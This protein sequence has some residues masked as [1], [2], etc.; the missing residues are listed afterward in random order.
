MKCG[1]SFSYVPSSLILET[2]IDAHLA[3]K[4][5]GAFYSARSFMT[6]STKARRWTLSL[7]DT[8]CTPITTS[9]TELFP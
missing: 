5:S 9:S 7:A 1:L 4:K 8:N 3:T 2:L 6:V